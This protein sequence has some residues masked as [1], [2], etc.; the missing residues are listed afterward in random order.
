MI[1]ENI[2]RLKASISD[3]CQRIK[4]DPQEIIII[5]VTKYSD[6]ASI[7]EA[8]GAGI[9]HIAENRLQQ[10]IVKYAGLVGVT[11]HMIEIGRASC[12]E[13]V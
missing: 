1:S 3:I 7:D 10:A 8:V 2:A 11:K 12:R 6:R 4:K 9:A 5:G 13:R